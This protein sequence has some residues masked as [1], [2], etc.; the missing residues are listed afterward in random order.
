MK[1]FLESSTWGNYR[2]LVEITY[3]HS[4]RFVCLVCNKIITF[5]TPLWHDAPSCW[6][7]RAQSKCLCKNKQTTSMGQYWILNSVVGEV[8]SWGLVWLLFLFLRSSSV[9]NPITQA[10]C[11]QTTPRKKEFKLKSKTC[12]CL[13]EKFAF[14]KHILINQFVTVLS[15]ETNYGFFLR[16]FTAGRPLTS[17]SRRSTV[18]TCLCIWLSVTP[19]MKEKRL[20][21]H[22]YILGKLG[23][24]AVK[25][26]PH[27]LWTETTVQVFNTSDVVK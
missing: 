24:K 16:D 11:K 2:W 13:L 18:S 21:T 22:K 14:I 8:I 27:C 23:L 10:K 6:D 17:S 19:S 26:S 4:W 12:K 7:N 25:W 15:R 1:L 20:R 5:I 9:V 3:S